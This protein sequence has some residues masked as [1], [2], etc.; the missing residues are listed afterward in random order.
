MTSSQ[1]WRHIQER[2]YYVM[3]HK[4][5]HA[6]TAAMYKMHTQKYNNIFAQV[7]NVFYISWKKFK[8]FL[9]E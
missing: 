6:P 7:A 2:S 3:S 9:G 1:L 8:K 4:S 5:Q